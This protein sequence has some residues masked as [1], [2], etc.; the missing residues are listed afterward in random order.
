VVMNP[1][2]I[3][4]WREYLAG[5]MQERCGVAKQVAQNTVTL[6]LRSL[7]REHEVYRI[8]SSIRTQRPS[9]RT[10]SGTT[11]SRSARA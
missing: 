6:W 9:V 1:D 8:P 3:A 2:H 4:Q 5:Q 11:Q 7:K 10:K